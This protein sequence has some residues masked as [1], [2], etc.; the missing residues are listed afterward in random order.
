[1]SPQLVTAPHTKSVATEG[2]KY[3]VLFVFVPMIVTKE[4]QRKRTGCVTPPKFKGRLETR[5]TVQSGN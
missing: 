5:A 2:T 1:M 3:L 4:E